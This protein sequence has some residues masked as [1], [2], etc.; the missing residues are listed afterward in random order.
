M[1]P[2]PPRHSRRR[3]TRHGGASQL[4]CALPT[5]AH[6][7]QGITKTPN[8]K[9]LATNHIDNLRCRRRRC[10]GSP[11]PSLTTP[12]PCPLRFGL[13]VPQRFA[14]ARSPHRGCALAA[15]PGCGRR[16]SAPPRTLGG[17]ARTEGNGST[18]RG[19]AT[20][21]GCAAVVSVSTGRPSTGFG[22]LVL[23]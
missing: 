1:I 7:S 11:S 3:S 21:R 5:L 20:A 23:D 18:C 9:T 22:R 2:R 8:P 12:L 17:V 10:L 15:G 14:R 6:S 4:P 19:R 13:V 16:C